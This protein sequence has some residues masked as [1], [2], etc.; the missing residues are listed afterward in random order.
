[1]RGRVRAW[2]V[3]AGFALCVPQTVQA[4]E[5]AASTDIEVLVKK[6]GD[7]QHAVRVSATQA[8]AARAAREYERLDA[9]YSNCDDPEVRTRLCE[10]LKPWRPGAEVWSFDLGA[11]SGEYGYDTPPEVR[12]ETVFVAQTNGELVALKASDGTKRW[13]FRSGENTIFPALSVAD[14]ACIVSCQG[15]VRARKAGTGDEAWSSATCGA[16]ASPPIARGG[17]IY[18]VS[19]ACEPNGQVSCLDADSGRLRWA[20][21]VQEGKVQ[22]E[23]ILLEDRLVFAHTSNQLPDKRYKIAGVDLATGKLLWEFEVATLK[24]PLVSAAHGAVYA[25]AGRRLLALNAKD[26]VKL[27]E[28]DVDCEVLDLLPGGDGSLLGIGDDR[29]LRVWETKDGAL[30][31]SSERPIFRRITPLLTE[32]RIFFAPEENTLECADLRDGRRLWHAD[33]AEPLR[34]PLV[35]GPGF[36]LVPGDRG[37]LTCLRETDGKTLWWRAETF[38]TPV[39]AGPFILVGFQSNQGGKV[40][41]L[42]SGLK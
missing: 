17:A 19:N 3:A 32:S 11:S 10:I 41:C 22:Q 8:L 13:A 30:R 39:L 6:L 23:L 25:A 12:G 4:E 18:L 26:G 34:G 9:L 31:W 1:M 7:E 35:K 42:R 5:P 36:L 16:V 27:S 33:L 21:K 14:A 2:V 37:T 29:K 24:P 38:G 28:R 20:C 40:V 15:K